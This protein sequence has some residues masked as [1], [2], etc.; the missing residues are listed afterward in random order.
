[1]LK[2]WIYMTLYFYISALYEI[3]ELSFTNEEI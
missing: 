2:S 3:I 1:M